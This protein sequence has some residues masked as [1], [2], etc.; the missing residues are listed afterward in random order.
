MIVLN[1]IFGIAFGAAVPW[2]E[3]K[4]KEWAE[5]I[6]LGELPISEHEYD[7]V[8]VLAIVMIAAIVCAVFRVDSSAFLLAL[9][10]ATGLFAGRIWKRIRME[11][12][13]APD[14]ATVPDTA[15]AEGA[16]GDRR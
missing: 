15:S 12:G 1:F 2:L 11:A 5:Q 14:P 6:Y 13:P 4:L 9:G 3:R 16:T 8:A 10:I 7:V